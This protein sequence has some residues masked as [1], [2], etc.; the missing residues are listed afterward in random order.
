MNINDLFEL[1]LGENRGIPQKQ[2]AKSRRHPHTVARLIVE[3]QQKRQRR[4][5]R[6][7]KNAEAQRKGE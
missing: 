1:A 4:R 6:N 2:S 5:E 3:A 7:R